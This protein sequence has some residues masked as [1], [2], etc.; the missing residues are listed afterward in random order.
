MRYAVE[1]L[2]KQGLRLVYYLDDICLLARSKEEMQQISYKVI[3]HLSKLGFLINWEKSNLIPSTSQEFLGFQFNTRS[4]KITVPQLKMSKLLTRIKQAKRTEHTRSCRWIASLLGKMTSL[5][6][7]IDEALLHLRYLQR[8]LA[9]NLRRNNMNWEGH[10]PLS[11]EGLQD[12]LWWENSSTRKNGLP[13]Q[14]IQIQKSTPA[15]TIHVDASETGWGIKSNLLTTSG[16]WTTRE[17][18]LSINVRE[19][20]TILFAIQL[21]AKNANGSAI[22]IFTDNMTALKYVTKAGG[23]AEVYLQGLALQI[24]EQF[25]RHNLQV[26]FHHIPEVKN[27]Q[28]DR[29]NRTKIPIYEWKLPRRWFQA[30]QNLWGRMR[31]DAFAAR[32]N[33]QLKTFSSLRPYPAAAAAAV[34]A[35]QQRWPRRGLYLHPPW[36]LIPS[37]ASTSCQVA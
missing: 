8:D 7:A 33:H 4:M 36:K 2:R 18:D 5:I 16:Y 24:Q 12:L 1:P 22:Q 37:M 32:H 26:T 25:N 15:M 10:C 28:A 14:T 17:K 23:T 13:V 27:I 9:R 29:L 34:D 11:T 31:I 35:F 6:P 3:S 19:L 21:H 30:I 20:K